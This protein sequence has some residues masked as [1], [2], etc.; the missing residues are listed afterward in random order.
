M[1]FSLPQA[2]DE[3]F[4]PPSRGVGA[5]GRK[6]QK[7][8]Q[9]RTIPTSVY[10]GIKKPPQYSFGAGQ[11]G[12]HKTR[13]S[14]L[15]YKNYKPPAP[16]IKR[17]ELIYEPPR[18]DESDDE[19]DPN[20]EYV[21]VQ[22]IVE[23]D[24]EYE[25]DD[26]LPVSRAATL[27]GAPQFDMQRF[28]EK[29]SDDEEERPTVKIRVTRKV[30]KRVYEADP[31]FTLQ[32]TLPNI[33]RGKISKLV[34]QKQKAMQLGMIALQKHHAPR[35]EPITVFEEVQKPPVPDEE[36][37][38]LTKTFAEM[39]QEAKESDVPPPKPQSDA[40]KRHALNLFLSKQKVTTSE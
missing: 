8:K 11:V 22:E 37:P 3:Q 35:A 29:G 26:D 40:Y 1:S 19:I 31:D 7:W 28:I 4:Y 12:Y 5:V 38:D 32:Q 23:Q 20:E 24:V 30:P 25:S 14:A 10:Q 33:S 2:A 6:Q 34:Q 15:R 13:Q 9:R 16:K 21:T 18:E 27:P 17:P 39:V 36:V